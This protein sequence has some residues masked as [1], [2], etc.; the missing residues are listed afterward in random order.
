MNFR[1]GLVR[2]L[3]DSGFEVVILAERDDSISKLR[4]LPIRYIRLSVRSQSMNPIRDLRL[5]GQYL[6]LFARERSRAA[7]LLAFT[8]K[9]NIYG[10]IAAQLFRIPVIN[11]VAGLGTLFNGSAGATFLARRLYQGA[12]FLSKRVF[13]QNTF[14]QA[15]FLD[16]KL[17]RPGQSALL[18][19]SGVD[20]VR[21]SEHEYDPDDSPEASQSLPVP[22]GNAVPLSEHN[23]RIGQDR[24][25]STDFLMV[26]RL[27]WDKGLQEYAEAARIVKMRFPT[28]NF[29][30]AGFVEH[31]HSTAVP[32]E[33]IQA[34]EA[35]GLVHFVGRLHDVRPNIRAAR[36]VVHPT[37]YREGTP[38]ILLEAAAMGRAIVTTDVPGCR[39][40]VVEGVN[41][42]L[43]RPRDAKD[44][45]E[46]LE[47]VLTMSGEALQKMGRAGRRHVET[48]YDERLVIEAYQRE[49][50]ELT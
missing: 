38:R 3:I 7:A 43:C 36:C 31:R 20:L 29:T 11:N 25:G 1:M 2:A 19:G 35:D 41:G 17:V 50:A 12:L 28:A 32:A 18:P 16:R 39:D 44:L 49:L 14:D 33:H 47:R 9:P 5:F 37:A 8:V 48:H 24:P 40:V 23:V 30:L 4:T 13:F 34:W 21:F 27:L 22:S 45:A 26:S 42:F 6:H 46:K 15:L 10:S